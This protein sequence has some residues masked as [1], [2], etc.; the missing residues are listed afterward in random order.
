M[1]DVVVTVPKR[2]WKDWISEGDAAGDPPMGEEWGFYTWGP[3]P[4]IQPGER[5]YIV[6]HGKIRGYAPLIRATF[7]PKTWE[8]RIGKM[9]RVVFVRAAGAVAV[10]I[11]A[12]VP[13]FRGYR[14]RWWD[15][16]LERLF[17]SWRMP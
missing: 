4:E 13:G 5:V 8:K 1:S 2:I 11:E 17:P 7:E 12:A 14:Y 6:A 10:T 9:G 3:K 16:D 15:L